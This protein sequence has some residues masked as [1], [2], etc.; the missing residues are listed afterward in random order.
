MDGVL[1]SYI[2]WLLHG[3]ILN[4]CRIC[5]YFFFQIQNCSETL[6]GAC[7]ELV[8]KNTSYNFMT[9]RCLL[10]KEFDELVGIKHF[11][12]AMLST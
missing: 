7:D 11:E 4:Y 3:C 1:I 6:V 9:L 8:A 2:M 12:T 10:V 5:H